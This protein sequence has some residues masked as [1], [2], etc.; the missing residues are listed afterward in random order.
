MM[1]ETNLSSI[2]D[3]L[4]HPNLPSTFSFILVY[5][6]NLTS[7]PDSIVTYWSKLVVG[8][9]VIWRYTTHD[10]TLQFLSTHD[11]QIGFDSMS[12]GNTLKWFSDN[13][14]IDQ[15]LNDGL[16][17]ESASRWSALFQYLDSITCCQQHISKLLSW[18]P[19]WLARP[20]VD[21]TKVIVSFAGNPLCNINPSPS[22]CSPPS[23]DDTIYPID[24]I[25]AQRPF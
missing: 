17:T 22:Y 14:W 20:P 7:L 6:S 10:I 11:T 9:H 24:F 13:E 19:P 15:V 16:S 2:L 21:G 1:L 23:S 3:A 25:V 8:A 12:H 4:L 5:R 18:V